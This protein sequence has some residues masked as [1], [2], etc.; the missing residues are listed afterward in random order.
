[1]EEAYF[2][3]ISLRMKAALLNNKAL[4]TY[5]CVWASELLKQLTDSHET[6]LERHAKRRPQIVSLQFIIIGNTSYERGASNNLW[7]QK[8]TSANQTR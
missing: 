1:M 2:S 7:S 3:L 6:Y 4:T 8:D 5:I